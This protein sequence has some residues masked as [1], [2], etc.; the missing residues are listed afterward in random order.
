[1]YSLE[2]LAIFRR[3]LLY[4]RKGKRRDRSNSR[5]HEIRFF[6]FEFNVMGV[7]MTR[8][9]LKTESFVPRFTTALL[10]VVPELS[11]GIQI[12]MAAWKK[13]D[14]LDYVKRDNRRQ[15][16]IFTFFVIFFFLWIIKQMLKTVFNLENTM[17]PNKYRTNTVLYLYSSAKTIHL[18]QMVINRHCAVGGKRSDLAYRSNIV[19]I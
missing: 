17:A 2:K 6:V 4:G 3:W 12:G 1:M 14:K 10:D 19:Y 16:S 15:K 11:S 18:M 8:V 9:I 7:K 13:I 5:V